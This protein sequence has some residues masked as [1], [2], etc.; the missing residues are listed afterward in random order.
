MYKRQEEVAEVNEVLCEGCGTC[1]AACPS[2]AMSLR[3]LADEQ[4]EAMVQAVLEEV[5]GG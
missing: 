4:V 3:N 5:A 2:G 1:V